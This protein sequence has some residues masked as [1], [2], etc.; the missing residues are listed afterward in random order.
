MNGSGGQLVV[1]D[2]T[3]PI[4]GVTYQGS[5]EVIGTAYGIWIEGIRSATEADVDKQNAQFID[6]HIMACWQNPGQ[7]APMTIGTIVRL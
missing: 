3:N 7:G 1:T 4:A 6:F 2:S 5:P